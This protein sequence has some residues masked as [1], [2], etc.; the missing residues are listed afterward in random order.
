MKPAQ[1]IRFATTAPPLRLALALLLLCISRQAMSCELDAAY[2]FHIEAQSLSETLLLI[3]RASGCTVSFKPDNTRDY[4]SQPING[5]LSVRQAMGLALIDSDLET[6]QTRN[7]SL[8]VRKR[9]AAPRYV[10]E[11]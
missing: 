1:R 5:R 9:G 4:Q 7:G 8:T 3:G 6:L 2:P 11:E 10:G